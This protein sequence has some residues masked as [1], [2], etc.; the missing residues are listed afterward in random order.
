MDTCF[1]RTLIFLDPIYVQISFNNGIFWQTLMT[2]FIRDKPWL[3]EFSNEEIIQLHLIRIR[4]FQRVSTSMKKRFFVGLKY[5]YYF[6]EWRSN[7]IL[8][9][10]ELIPEKLPNQWIS[11]N[12]SLIHTCNYK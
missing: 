10:F 5:Y 8:K 1:N 2:I 11:R 12:N 3:I 7:W 9:K 4:L 6:L